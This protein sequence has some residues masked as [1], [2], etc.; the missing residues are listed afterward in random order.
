[1]PTAERRRMP[2]LEEQAGRT[3][4]G[5]VD[6]ARDD[7]H[8]RVRQMTISDWALREGIVLDAVRVARPRRLVRRPARAAP[9]R[10]GRARPPVQLR[11]RA[12]ATSRASRC[13][14]RPDQALHGLGAGDRE[15]LEY[16]ALLHD[17]GQHVSR[18]AITGT[19]RTSWSTASSAASPPTRSSSSPRSCATTGGATRRRRA[20]LRPRS[21]TT[22]PAAQARRAAADRRRARP[23]P[24]G[25]VEDVD[26]AGRRQPRD[27]PPPRPA[28]TPSSSSGA[29]G[30]G[31]TCSRRSSTASSS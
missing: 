13:A 18:R 31:A 2:G 27:A 16:A 24:R 25:V 3:A 21:T 29:P 19:G 28:T 23:R 12:P 14:L 10:G 6:V 17:I 11:R 1:M 22:G 7:R 26:V 4:P 30:A 20:A 8:V 9:R 5:R 15:L